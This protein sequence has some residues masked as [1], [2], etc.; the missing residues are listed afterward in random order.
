VVEGDAGWPDGVD[1][2]DGRAVQPCD[3]SAGPA[4]EDVAQRGQLLVAGAAST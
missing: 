4:E 3:R 2:A 1:L